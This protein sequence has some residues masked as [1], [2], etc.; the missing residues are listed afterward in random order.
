VTNR[1]GPCCAASERLSTLSRSLRRTRDGSAER[2]GKSDCESERTVLPST[3]TPEE[4]RATATP[5]PMLCE[6]LGSPAREPTRSAWVVA[7]GF[8][9]GLSCVGVLAL[10]LLLL[11]ACRGV[12]RQPKLA[13]SER[14]SA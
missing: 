5:R 13:V 1:P 14:H 7:G 8:W 2:D 12:R 9:A 11:R 3:S 10:A 6:A 4:A